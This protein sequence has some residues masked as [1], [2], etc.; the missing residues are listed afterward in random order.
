V[1][2]VLND[3]QHPYTRGLLASVPARDGAR[4]RP[5]EG[6]VPVLGAFPEGCAFHP[7]CPD[8]FEPCDVTPPEAYA[9]APGRQVRCYLHAP[10]ASSGRRPLDADTSNV[11]PWRSLKSKTS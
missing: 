11:P 6:A 10:D 7:R 1:R 3:P 9:T 8:R 4:L 2:D 5:I